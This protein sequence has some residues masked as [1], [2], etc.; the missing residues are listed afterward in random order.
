MYVFY[1]EVLELVGHDFFVELRVMPA[2]WNRPHV[3]N[4]VYVVSF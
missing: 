1:S 3:N 2:T 4:Q